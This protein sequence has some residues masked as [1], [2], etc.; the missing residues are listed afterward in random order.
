[1]QGL[2]QAYSRTNRLYGPEKEF[3][4]IVNFMWPAI[5]EEKVKTAL[6]LYGSGD[7]NTPSS[8]IVDTYDVAVRKLNEKIHD[9]FAALKIHQ[10]GSY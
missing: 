8:A 3:G 4:T 10:I 5:T 6:I 1:M 7:E 2:V 9:M